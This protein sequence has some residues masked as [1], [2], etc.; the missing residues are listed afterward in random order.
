MVLWLKGL[1]FGFGAG[2]LT[3]AAVS[4]VSAL[5]SSEDR[6]PERP[7][8]VVH[9]APAATGETAAQPD[10]SA[11]ARVQ[12]LVAQEGAPIPAPAFLDPPPSREVL[13]VEPA[14]SRRAKELAVINDVRAA[15]IAKN[16]QAALDQLNQ[17][18]LLYPEASFGLP[19]RLLRIEALAV[20]GRFQAAQELASAFVAA[21]PDSPHAARL[22]AFASGEALPD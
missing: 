10:T 9:P 6:A 12:G 3:M 1:A 18:E 5:G 17:Y 13:P 11:I 22:R 19:A 15:L 14:H 2:V 20:S 7:S 4:L 21:H 8:A 16:P